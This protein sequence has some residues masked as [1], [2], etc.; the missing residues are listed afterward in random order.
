MV[1]I[2]NYY[3]ELEELQSFSK[4]ESSTRRPFENLLS[5]F[6]R[7]RNLSLVPEVSFGDIRPDGVVKDKFEF[8]IGFWEAKDLKDNLD[9]EISKKLEK[10]YPVSNIIFENSKFAILFQNG[11]SVL[12][13]EMEKAEKLEELLE[14]F[15]K[16]ENPEKRKFE[17]NLE[18]FSEAVPKLVDEVRRRISSSE[19]KPKFQK[20]YRRLE[21]IC[22]ESIDRNIS[23]SEILEMLIQHILTEEIFVNLFSTD[24]HKENNI[25]K[26][27]N[28]LEIAVFSRNEKKA[29]FHK[30]RNF[31]DA[32]KTH[33]VYLK[34]Y[35]EKHQFLNALYESFYKA[36]NP[37]RADKLGIVYTPFEIVDF[38]IEATDGILRKSFKKSLS[39]KGVQILDPATG[40]GT[41]LTQIMNWI[42]K[43]DLVRK[44]GSELFANEIA[45]LPYYIANI[46]FEYIYFQRTGEFRDFEN[47]SFVDTLELSQNQ[48]GQG[49][50]LFSE[51]NTERV[52]RQEDSDFTVIIGN[53]PYNANQQNE[54]DNNKNRAYPRVDSRIK[55]TYVK[56]SSAQ[57]TKVYD[58]YSRFYRWATD[59][60]GK[61]GIVA[62]VTNSSFIDSKT[63]DGFR[64]TIFSEF[65][66][67]WILDLGG[68][69]RKSEKDGNVFD[70]MVGVAIAFF[71]KRETESPTKLHYLKNPEI[72]KENKLLWLQRNGKRFFDLDWEDI[73]PDEKGNWLNQ[74]DNDWE[75]LLPMGTKETKLGKEENA[76]FRNF[77]NGISTNR[78]EW[79]YD[80]DKENLKRKA[81]YFIEKYNLELERW[82][83]FIID[84]KLENEKFKETDK[85]LNDFLHLKNL[86][87]WTKM[88]KRDK[89]LKNKK[90]IF[91]KDKIRHSL[92]RP[93]VKQYLNSNYIFIDLPAQQF[94][95]FPTSE[96]EN[97]V[98]SVSGTSHSKPFQALGV[99]LLPNLD[100]LEK[101]KS[102]PLHT[103]TE[104]SKVENITDF[105]LEKFSVR[106]GKVIKLQIFHYI[107]AVLH[108]PEYREKYETNLK[109]DLPRIPFYENF[110]LFSKVGKSL[111]ELH[112]D[113]EKAKEF[114][115]DFGKVSRKD[116]SKK[117]FIN[118]FPKE[119]L[120]YKLGNRSAIEWV[121]DGY[122]E[123]KIRDETVREKF[124]K[125]EIDFDEVLSLL[126]KV[127]TVSLETLE[128]LRELES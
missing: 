2:E 107:Y 49:E 109:Q 48:K 73:F 37:K 11:E 105:A 66:E 125:S 36:Y 119:A 89:F 126:K 68:N 97:V 30:I 22:Q 31:Y 114:S 32:I 88:I 80:F 41:F 75:E 3:R 27:L 40:T 35:R 39:S 123:K 59:R 86:I 10:G 87:K 43:R 100:L 116:L 12:E 63:F 122:K 56:T 50:F 42:P 46:N 23:K 101:T 120:E 13:I 52:N 124:G 5:S 7:E 55:D 1:E 8:D 38:M 91:S 96:S 25:A 14:T 24:F 117:S 58:M 104:N 47:I 110:S 18:K 17:E 28:E 84:N 9:S 51:E 74:T 95:A 4:N 111:L 113:F 61:S 98:I 85:R 62:F 6:A 81:E 45:I 79:V 127:T 99:S 64:K 102:F 67:I 19:E 16:F 83:K 65:S 29:L 82:R 103:F 90:A 15:F 57:K 77:S 118:F 78:D 108:F 115:I 92:Y 34:G 20:A 44:Y 106:Y 54:N 71:V 53:P 70:I 72:G 60:I 26:I 76:I 121:I 69:V 112:T 21:A 128:L 94:D 93:F 33:S